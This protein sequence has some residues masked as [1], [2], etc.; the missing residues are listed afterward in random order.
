MARKVWVLTYE[1]ND[2]DQHGEYFLAAFESKPDYQK[3]ATALRGQPGMPT[4]IMSGIAF[5]DH[6][7]KG[8]GRKKDEGMWYNLEEVNLI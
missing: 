1:V 4:D 8:G 3:L 6:V 5:L 2:Y 7:L